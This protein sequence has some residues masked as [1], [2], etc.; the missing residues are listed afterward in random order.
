MTKSVEKTIKDIAKIHMN[1]QGLVRVGEIRAV[2]IK[3]DELTKIYDRNS[4]YLN[5]QIIALQNENE[6][7]ESQLTR[8]MLK[9]STADNKLQKELRGGK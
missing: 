8:Y 9:Y 7:L 6:R 5:E 1:I 2:T 3:L 4:D